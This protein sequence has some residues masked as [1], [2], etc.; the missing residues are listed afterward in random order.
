MECRAAK[1]EPRDD[2]L[3]AKAVSAPALQNL[4][5][6]YEQ[7]LTHEA[8]RNACAALSRRS[9]AQTDAPLSDWHRRPHRSEN[10]GVRPSSGAAKPRSVCVVEPP[11]A[12][13]LHRFAVAGDGHTPIPKAPE[14]QRTPRRFALAVIPPPPRGCVR[15]CFL[16]RHPL[17]LKGISAHRPWSRDTDLLGFRVSLL[18]SPAPRAQQA[19]RKFLTSN[20]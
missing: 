12:L 19:A 5:E 15:C 18:T 3:N 7:L 2:I 4:A 6:V 1:W 20:L 11:N 8:S 16:V 9:A 17:N 10:P 14:R 13:T